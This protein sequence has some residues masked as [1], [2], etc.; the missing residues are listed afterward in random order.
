MNAQPK[1]P[2]DKPKIPPEAYNALVGSA[3]LSAI[4]LIESDFALRLEGL[5]DEQSWRHAQS[6]EIQDARYDA[7][8]SLLTAFVSA[9]AHA[10][11]KR[12]HVISVKC[13]YVIYYRVEG[14]L[15]E[16]AVVEFANRV[17]RFTAYPYFRT[18]FAELMSQAGVYAP[19]LPI[20][21]EKRFFTG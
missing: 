9:V 17:A 20:I 3:E 5:G 10:S 4:R 12:K 16:A 15:E 2:G 6:C 14:E 8:N 1:K 11:L 19:P 18:H 7:E 13:R 21:K